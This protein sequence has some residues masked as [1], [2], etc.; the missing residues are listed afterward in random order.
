M[1]A[2]DKSGATVELANTAGSITIMPAI[3]PGDANGDGKV[4]AKDVSLLKKYIAGIVND[5]EVNFLNADIN[6]D[7]KINSRDLAELKKIIAGL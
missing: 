6:G 2:K 1:S 3:E 7:G 5:D 4:T